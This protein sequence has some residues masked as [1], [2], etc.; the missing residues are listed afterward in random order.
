MNIITTN[1]PDE[2]RQLCDQLLADGVFNA[3]PRFIGKIILEGG[4]HIKQLSMIPNVGW[5][6]VYAIGKSYASRVATYVKPE[7]RRKG[8]GTLLFNE[9]V[10]HRPSEALYHG[11]GTYAGNAFFA[12]QRR[13]YPN[14]HETLL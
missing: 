14:L 11:C 2:V 3:D 13:Q 1:K 8:Y 10:K 9:I 6:V 4:Y 12:R 7:E 5:C